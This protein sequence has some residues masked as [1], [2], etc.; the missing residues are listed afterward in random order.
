[1]ENVPFCGF[2][3]FFGRSDTWQHDTWQRILLYHIHVYCYIMWHNSLFQNVNPVCTSDYQN[4]RLTL[5]S[6]WIWSFWC[7][8]QTDW[9]KFL[10]RSENWLDWRGWLWVITHYP[11]F[12]LPS[13]NYNN[14]RAFTSP[15]T[16]SLPSQ[17]GS[18]PSKSWSFW[19]FLTMRFMRYLET[20]Q[21][22][23][24]SILLSCSS[25]ALRLCRTLFVEWQ[26]STVSG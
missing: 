2:F 5:G 20:S 19:M 16:A 21:S 13:P 18:A 15:I 14:Y 25:I 9:R 11:L 3:I 1:M 12:R 24:I 10:K 8:T 6:W 26:L 4:S 23:S 22:S 17:R 7:W